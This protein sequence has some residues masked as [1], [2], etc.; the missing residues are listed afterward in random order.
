LSNDLLQNWDS[1]YSAD[2]FP[3][4]KGFAGLSINWEPNR[5]ISYEK[6]D[7][8]LLIK[9]F[10]NTFEGLCSCL[11]IDKTWLLYKNEP[12]NGFQEWHQDLKLGCTITKTIVNNLACIINTKQQRSRKLHIA[13]CQCDYGIHYCLL[14]FNTPPD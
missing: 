13:E 10:V 4:S 2:E 8:R 11:S 9:A 12:G 1:A 6:L 5:Q 3:P 7:Q 14:K